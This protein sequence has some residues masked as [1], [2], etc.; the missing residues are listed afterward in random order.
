[1]H[2]SLIQFTLPSVPLVNSHTILD[3]LSP[4]HFLWASLTYSIL[5]F[6]WAFAMSSGLPWPNYHILY[7]QGL[8]AF[9][10]TPFT[11]S[12]LWAPLT[13]FCLLSISYNSH[14]LTTSF[15]RLPWARLLSLGP[16]YYFMPVNHYS[17]HSDLMVFFSHFANSSSLFPSILLGFFLLLGLLAKVGINTNQYQWLPV[18]AQTCN[19]IYLHT[20]TINITLM[21]SRF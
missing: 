3:F 1:M 20:Y 7:F 18:H 17:C 4:F 10:P 19:G 12:F 15:S 6:P 5:I 16:F 11:N 14:W 9:V 13:H 21:H 8:L 2:F